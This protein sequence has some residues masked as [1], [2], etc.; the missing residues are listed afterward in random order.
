LVTALAGDVGKLPVPRAARLGI[1]YVPV[2][3][4]PGNE[5]ELA[6]TDVHVTRWPLG[7]EA[8]VRAGLAGKAQRAALAAF[9]QL[10]AV[11]RQ[12][13]RMCRARW[14]AF[15]IERPFDLIFGKSVHEDGARMIED[16]AVGLTIGRTQ[17]ASNHLA[18]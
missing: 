12:S 2:H 7:Q 9:Q 14:M 16:D 11:P 4:P 6:V 18:K 3:L 17:P 13:C 5:P 8:T 1:V 15:G 10:G